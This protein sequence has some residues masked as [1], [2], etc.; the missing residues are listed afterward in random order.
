MKYDFLIV[1]AGFF[2]SIFAYL[3]NKSGKKCLVI[4]KRDHIGGNCYTKRIDGID[5]HQYGPHIFNTNNKEIWDFVNQFSK[6]NNFI[7]TPK[8]LNDGKIYS[9]P[10]N[11]MTFHQFFGS[12]TPHEARESLKKRI[13]KISNPK[14]LE[15]HILSQI[16]EE[17]YSTLIKGYTT[18]QWGRD[19]KFLPASIIKR[20]P[21]RFDFD[22]NYYN[23][24]YQGIPKDGYTAIFK[25][26]LQGIDLELNTDFMKDRLHLQD[27]ARSIIYTGPIDEYYS[28]SYG[29]L[30]YRSLRFQHSSISPEKSQGNVAINF[31]DKDIP[32]TRIIEHHFFTKKKDSIEKV[33]TTSEIPYE[34]KIG[35]TPYYPIN[36]DKNKATYMSYKIESQK[37]KNIFFCG[38]LG[39]YKYYNMDQIIA[40]AIRL[41]EKLL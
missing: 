36:D 15:E 31:T 1:G 38:R 26:L 11:M 23:S 5:I 32:Y 40:K 33:C 7:Y 35:D 22:E 14:N 25:K 37:H 9:L 10:I 18:K 2:G 6:F 24:K 34:H 29:K 4:D 3:A 20:I 17:I 28:Y 41:S 39:E 8:A 19:P 27:K 21:I 16:G 30:D 13:V 12:C